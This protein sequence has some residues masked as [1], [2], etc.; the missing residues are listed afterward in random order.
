[1]PPKLSDRSVE[2]LQLEFGGVD[3]P[4]RLEATR[5]VLRK[6]AKDSMW[7]FCRYAL[8]LPDIETD[9][10]RDMCW[11]WQKRMHRNFSLWLIPRGHLKT[12]LWTEGGTLWDL[13]NNADQRYLVT[14]AKLE[15]ASAI[16]AN[17]RSYTLGKEIFRWLFPEYCLDLAPR[18]LRDR[19]RDT[20]ERIDFPCSIYAG[21]KEGNIQVM[22]VEAS[23]VSRHYDV[24]VFDDPV[25]DVNAQTKLLRDKV[26]T[27]YKNSL[28][29]RHSPRESRVRL[30]GTRWHF[31]DLYSRLIKEENTRRE[32]QTLAGK[33]VKPRYYM[34][35]RKVKE[36][37]AQGVEKP[38]WPERYTDDVI[39]GIKS[40]VG[41]YVF[42]CQ[43][44]NNPLPDE[45][46]IFKFQDIQF[47]D[48]M[49]IPDNVVNFCA[50]DLAYEDSVERGDFTCITVASFDSD[51]KM[52]VREIIRDKIFPLQLVEHIGRMVKRWK[53]KRVGVETTAFQSTIYKFNKAESFK[54]GI[55]IPWVEL[56]R[57][58]TAKKKRILA[59]QPRVERKDFYVQAGIPN[60]EWL[61]DEMTTYDKGAHDDILDTLADIEALAYA[62][63]AYEQTEALTVATLDSM[64]GSI[65]DSEDGSSEDYVPNVNLLEDVL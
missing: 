36:S 20:H 24:M 14:N 10:H 35:V 56:K 21:R 46:A 28:Q 32:N 64:Y 29:L 5:Q 59:L 13:V 19:C 52:Y 53:V 33:K 26:Y 38:I 63:Q 18:H 45:A 65:F 2:L 25:N 61:I 16:L 37:D 34:Y 50:V 22:A 60:Q 55:N 44:Q 57:G 42:S 58:R 47:I 31:D 23:L 9:L 48:E 4:R 49:A 30:I 15:N 11:T 8:E 62:A 7:F 54:T 41:S 12:T 6:R 17:I 39:A 1:M 3:G 27:W 43:F 51:G 40:E